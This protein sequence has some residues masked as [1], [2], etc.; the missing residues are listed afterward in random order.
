MNDKLKPYALGICA[1]IICTYMYL[2]L[3][4]INT[5]MCIYLATYRKS[6]IHTMAAFYYV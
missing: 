2:C 1:Y 5:N 6:S 4:V 3:Y